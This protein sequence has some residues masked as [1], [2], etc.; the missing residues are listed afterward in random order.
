[1]QPCIAAIQMN[2]QDDLQQNLQTAGQLI[3]QA[4]DQGAKLIVLPEMFAIMGENKNK[5]G[6]EFGLGPIQDFLSEQASQHA[7]W[8]VGGTIP[9]KDFNTPGK[10]FAS[11]LLFNDKGQC[12]ARYDKVHLFDINLQSRQEIHQES[13]LI[14]PGKKVVVAATPFGRLGLAVCYDVRFPELFRAMLNQNVEII[15]LPSAFTYT[16][17][18]AHW[19]ILVR[20]RAIENLSYVVAACQTGNHMNKRKTYGHSMLVTPWGEVIE[21]LPEET[22]VISHAL[23]LAKLYKLRSEFPALSHRVI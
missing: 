11:C 4:V 16:T 3:Q 2:S 7:A 18:S 1:M 14:S 8:I 15:A 19:D 6:E 17:G 5:Y 22:G 23:D 21:T 13:K 12:E 10:V 9:L 20:A